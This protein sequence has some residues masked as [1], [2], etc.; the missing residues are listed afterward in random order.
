[1]PKSLGKDSTCSIARSLE[2]LGDR[3]TLLIL[4]EALIAGSTRFQEFREALGIAPNLLTQR[5][6]FLIDEG[7]LTRRTYREEGARARD[8]YVLTETGRS[9]NLVIA[10]LSDWAR[11]CR[12]RPDGT[13]PAFV[14]ED[15]GA[16]V[17]LAFVTGDGDQVNAQRLVA[18]RT[19]DRE[20]AG[21]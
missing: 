15:S 2:V 5:L 12:P 7:L 3:W 11:T 21:P 6:T 10:A 19:P 13:S 17:R 14:V 18:R 9:L 16:P 4:R 20:L 1:M 8:E